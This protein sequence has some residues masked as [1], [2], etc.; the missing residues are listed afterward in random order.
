MCSEVAYMLT[1][2]MFMCDVIWDVSDTSRLLR[3]LML[4]FMSCHVRQVFDKI[5]MTE[6]ILMTNKNLT[7]K[8]AD[9][10]I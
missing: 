8:F 2:G 6:K 4:F 10:K 3:F 1:D 5:L 7:K 9:K